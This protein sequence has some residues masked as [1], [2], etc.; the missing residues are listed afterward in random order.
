MFFLKRSKY[1]LRFNL[2]K[3]DY[4]FFFFN[5]KIGNNNG[6]VEL[7]LINSLNDSHPVSRTPDLKKKQMNFS[8]PHIESHDAPTVSSIS[9]LSMSKEIMIEL[10]NDLKCQQQ[11]HVQQLQSTT[12]EIIKDVKSAGGQRELKN[13]IRTAGLLDLDINTPTSSFPF[14]NVDSEANNDRE[15]DSSSIHSNYCNIGTEEETEE[16]KDDFEDETP[17]EIM[18]KESIGNGRTKQHET[19]RSKSNNM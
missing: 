15:V 12:K 4:L 9:S 19:Q 13:R 11:Q 2:F 7:D 17:S 6:Q 14:Q 10:S 18:G 16:D 8:P 5:F 3:S 1:W